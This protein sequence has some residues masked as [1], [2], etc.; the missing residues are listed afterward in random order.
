MSSAVSWCQ[1]AAKFPRPSNP[2]QEVRINYCDVH[3]EDTS[4]KHPVILLIHGFPLTSHQFK[5]VL[6]P[7]AKAGFRCIAPDYTGAGGSSKPDHGYSK[8]AIAADLHELI[9]VHLG[10]THDIHVVSH[11]IGA[12]IG[13]AY[14]SQYPEQ[15]ASVTLGECPIPGTSTFTEDKGDVGHFHVNFHAHTDLVVSLTAGREELYIRYFF[16]KQAYNTAAITDEDVAVFVTAYSQ[17]GAFRAACLTYKDFAQDLDDNVANLEK[18]GL[19]KV[20]AL[21]MGGAKSHHAG[22]AE[23]MLKQLYQSVDVL[24]LENTGHY[25]AMENPRGF[26]E[27][28]LAFMRKHG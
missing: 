19:C 15:L 13:H 17:P 4:T 7:L 14:A 16:D 18:H 25:L 22:R 1:R 21:A 6:E 2:Q 5:H 11:D 8:H 20:P 9:T 27:G 10:I 28:V 12:M 24:E 3:L 23:G 26:V